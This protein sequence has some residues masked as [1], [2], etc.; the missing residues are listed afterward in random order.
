MYISLH[1][2]Y[3]LLLSDFNKAWLLSTHFRKILNIKFHENP[4]SRSRIV[5]CGRTDRR[6]DEQTDITRLI[7]NV[8]QFCERAWKR[9]GCLT[10]VRLQLHIWR[11]THIWIVYE[12]EAATSQ[13]TSS[14]YIRKTYQLMTFSITPSIFCENCTKLTNMLLGGRWISFVH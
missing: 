14:I 1:V 2:R 9:S 7:V 13:R 11:L 12:T 8:S 10:K 3:P 6:T 5:P 4:S